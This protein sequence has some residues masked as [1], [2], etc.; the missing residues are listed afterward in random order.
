MRNHIIGLFAIL[1]STISFSAYS[2]DTISVKARPKVGLVL[3]GGGAKGAAHIGVIS[4][5]WDIHPLKSLTSS[6]R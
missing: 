4:M 6:V 2:Q 1:L 3:S 5:H